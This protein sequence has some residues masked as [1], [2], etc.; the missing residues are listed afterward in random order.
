MSREAAAAQSRA[1]GSIFPEFHANF[2]AVLQYSG[3]LTSGFVANY[4]FPFLY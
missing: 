4:Q 3:S 2:T 1:R